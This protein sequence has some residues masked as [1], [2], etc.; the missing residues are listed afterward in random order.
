MTTQSKG[1]IGRCRANVAPGLRCFGFHLFL[2]SVKH[3]GAIEM[4]SVRLA[5]FLPFLLALMVV[6]V[7]TPA[8]A[9]VS[10]G[11]ISGNITDPQ[12][13]A[14]PDATVVA[15]N[16]A[17]NQALTTTSD[18]AGLF[19]L[20]LVPPGTYRIEISKPGFR[21]AAFDNVEVAVGADRGLAAIKLEI[22]ELSASVEV[23]SAPPLVENTEAQITNEFTAANIQTFAG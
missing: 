22:G 20:S 18:N 23:F 4:K 21:K 3:M 17:T 2:S 10:N 19:R 14:V 13:A 9:Q 7:P 12:G 6:I 16:K 15:T 1:K 8:T 5:G 11:S